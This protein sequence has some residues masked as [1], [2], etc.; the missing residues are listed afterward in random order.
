MHVNKN[1]FVGKFRWGEFS[2]VIQKAMKRG[3]FEDSLL[4][5]DLQDARSLRVSQAAS[6]VLPTE[7]G[8]VTTQ[9]PHCLLGLGVQTHPACVRTK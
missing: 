7:L 9:E 6:F 4:Q 8:Q 2:R 1:S 3:L 5:V